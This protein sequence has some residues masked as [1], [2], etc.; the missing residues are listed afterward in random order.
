[1]YLKMMMERNPDFLSSV[2]DMVG[3][4]R[5]EPDTYALDVDSIMEN[6]ALLLAEGKRCGI[7]LFFMTKQFGRNPR[8]A[9]MLMEAGYPGAVAVDFREAT[10]LIE[11]GVCVMHAGH[12]VQ[13]PDA[14]IDRFV[15]SVRYITAFSVEKA[16]AIGKAARAASKIQD[17]FLRVVR[18]GDCIFPGQRGGFELERIDEIVPSLVQIE[19]IRIAGLTSFPCFTF[20]AGQRRFD[21]TANLE[22]I[23][24]AKRMIEERW[25]IPVPHLNMPSATCLET[26][27]MIAASGGT[28]GEPGHAF[29]GYTPKEAVETTPLKPAIVYATEV[30]HSCADRDGRAIS[31]L[32]GGG[33]YRRGHVRNAFL[34]VGGS[35]EVAKVIPPDP[36]F[37]DYYFDVEG[38]FPSGSPALMAF[39]TQVFATRSRVALVEGMRRGTPR[40]VEVYD[41]QGR[42]LE[43]R[44]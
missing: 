19:G 3:D 4:G 37:I 2:L 27:P 36:V 18:K 41:S 17:V 42:L 44:R 25:S 6:A 14:L 30:S 5:L 43:N 26:I 40:I 34:R 39:R 33:Y 12:L 31:C 11:N 24:R 9:R 7:D 16:S 1:M 28:Q 23:V 21:P 20:D 38:T 29:T 32:F 15:R 8:I 13:I 10:H 35:P 22:T